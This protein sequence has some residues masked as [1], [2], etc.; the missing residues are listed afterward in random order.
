MSERINIV[1][2]QWNKQWNQQNKQYT[3]HENND[4]YD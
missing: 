3:K 1:L 2:E 4:E